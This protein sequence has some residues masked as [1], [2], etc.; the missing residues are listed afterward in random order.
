MEIICSITG[1]HQRI[2]PVI[3]QLIIKVFLSDKF[4]KTKNTH[5]FWQH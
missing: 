4:D 3:F 5:I 2:R 1:Q